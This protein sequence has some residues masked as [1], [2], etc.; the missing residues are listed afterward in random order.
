MTP[1]PIM[2]ATKNDGSS[3]VG[4][5]RAAISG[6][7]TGDRAARLHLLRF[8]SIPSAASRQKPEGGRSDF[9]NTIGIIGIAEQSFREPKILADDSPDGQFQRISLHGFFD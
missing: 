8:A 7:S 3:F 5:R 6:K 9:C 2:D 1:C 4:E